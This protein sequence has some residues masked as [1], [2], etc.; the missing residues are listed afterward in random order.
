MKK[1]LCCIFIISSTFLV[2]QTQAQEVK[3][4]TKREGDLLKFYAH[5]T[6][7]CPYQCKIVITKPSLLKNSRIEP[8][9][10]IIPPSTSQFFLFEVRLK[11][12]QVT[13]MN[14]SSTIVMG[15]PHQARHEDDY[16]YQIPY[17]HKKKFRVIQGYDGA[18]SHKRQFA[19]DFKMPE[20]TPICAIREGIVIKTKSDSNQG[21]K[22]QSFAKDANYVIIYHRDGTFARYWH[23]K[24]ESVT[25][26]VGQRVNAGDV[27][28]FCGN[29]GWSTTP[30]LHLV[31]EKPVYL[32]MKSIPTK[33]MVNKFKRKYLKSWRKYTAFHPR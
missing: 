19:L 31:V 1:Y 15:D 30:H 7:P 33:F 27:I 12:A 18:Y 11:N 13:P 2:F 26:K 29:T 14:Y 3:I 25:V 10:G 5:N 8:Y 9:Y 17:E 20:G 16:S 6:F 4:T 28:G 22:N 24:F 32:K 23:L 21:G